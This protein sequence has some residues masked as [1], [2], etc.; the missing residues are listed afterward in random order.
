MTALT[1]R[2]IEA[3][4]EK[5]CS[6]LNRDQA[7]YARDALSKAIYGRMFDWLVNKINGSL[8]L[9]VHSERKECEFTPWR[10]H[11]KTVPTSEFRI[12]LLAVSID[13][14]TQLL[15]A[16]QHFHVCLFRFRANLSRSTLTTSDFLSL[17]IYSI[18][19][20]VR[21]VTSRN[22]RL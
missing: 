11:T 5:M 22:R 7:M 8:D 2:T 9:K 18:A 19:S 15:E 10:W 6:P 1:H 14:F 4:R 12:P 20:F 21:L 13:D 3:N 16:E 17:Y